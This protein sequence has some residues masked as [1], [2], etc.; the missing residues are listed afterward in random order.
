MNGIYLPNF[1][2]LSMNAILDTNKI[3]VFRILA[4]KNIF[5]DFPWL[6]SYKATITAHLQG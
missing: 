3:I 4:N 6:K 1:K 2:L 5:I